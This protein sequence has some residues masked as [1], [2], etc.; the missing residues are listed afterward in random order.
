[1]TERD[2][3]SDPWAEKITAYSARTRIEQ[4]DALRE[5]TLVRVV[6]AV[7]T[8][9]GATGNDAVAVVERYAGDRGSSGRHTVWGTSAT[10]DVEVAALVNGV[11]TRYLDFNDAY[12][13]LSSCHP[14]DVIPTMF[15]AA[16]ESGATDEVFLNGC[17]IAYEVIMRASDRMEPRLRGFDHVQMTILGALA[18]SARVTGLDEEQ[19]RHAIGIGVTSH[20]AL[21]QTRT[22][23]LSMWKA[24]AAADACRHGLYAV[25]LA[26]SGAQGP[27]APFTGL[28]AMFRRVMGWSEDE[29]PDI[30]LDSETQQPLGIANSQI[31]KFPCGSVGQSAAQ[32]G[33]DLV[34]MGHRLADV[35]SLHI[36]LDP[37]AYPLMVSPEK[38]QPTTRET[39]DHSI[40]YLIVSAL[41]RGQVTVESFDPSVIADPAVQAF[42]R[43]NVT[44]EEDPALEGGHERGFP[45][46]VTLR[47]QSGEAVE[48]AVEQIPGTPGNE[49]SLDE[50]REKF[51]RNLARSSVT[52]RSADLWDAVWRIGDSKSQDGL[53]E[54]NRLLRR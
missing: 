54:V 23:Q 38:L 11:R 7:G 32:T 35:E 49:M 43:E 19:T 22:G 26:A 14:S 42:L 48:H 16:L 9:L 51:D 30:S 33:E 6:D 5:A 39:A 21:R 45:V 29:F 13:G 34:A 24:F 12:Y 28:N 37:K 27:L 25:R 4:T 10:T 41:Q 36:R 15:A 46:A 2:V 20:V 8:A 47:L 53:L 3:T 44:V 31:K 40:P 17:Q 50:L 52:D 1:M 18:G